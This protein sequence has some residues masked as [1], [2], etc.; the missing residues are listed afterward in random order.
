M[1]FNKYFFENYPMDTPFDRNNPRYVLALDGVDEI[2]EKIIIKE[3]L[4]WI[5]IANIF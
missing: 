3:I 5:H 4:E 1:K 2:L